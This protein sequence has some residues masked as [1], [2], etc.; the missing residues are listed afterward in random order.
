MECTVPVE[1]HLATEHADVGSPE[2]AIGSALTEVEAGCGRSW[3]TNST[4]PSLCRAR[5]RCAQV[6]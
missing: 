6:S 4:R 5:V 1:V 2:R 3:W